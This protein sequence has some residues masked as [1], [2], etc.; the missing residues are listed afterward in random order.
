MKIQND[1]I[2]I[3]Y[4]Q[5]FNDRPHK[6][7][8]HFRPPLMH[9]VTP[10]PSPG[11]SPETGR[12]R[13]ERAHHRFARNFV[14]KR[15]IFQLSVLAPLVGAILLFIGLIQLTPGAEANPYALPLIIAGKYKR[16][17]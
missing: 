10:T 15:C 6:L 11:N 4:Q 13:R 3:F 12:N 9:Q 1:S 14:S 7:S 16:W 2:Y 17:A 5:C 8:L